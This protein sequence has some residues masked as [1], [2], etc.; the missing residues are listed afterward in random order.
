MKNTSL[1]FLPSFALLALLFS[2]QPN[3]EQKLKNTVKDYQKKQVDQP[4]KYKPG[5]FGE[6][7]SIFLEFSDVNEYKMLTDTSK[8]AAQIDGLSLRYENEMADNMDSLEKE[9]ERKK[10][11]LR[12]R[13]KS[14]EK[15][16]ENY[17][18]RLTKYVVPHTYKIA[19]DK[20]KKRFLV[21]TAYNVVGTKPAEKAE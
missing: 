9:L 16:K 21:D 12:E 17:E 7:D 11:N 14:I 1:A 20:H 10:E 5:Q 8:L 2:C 19:D 18:P 3:H 13:R 15:F 6:I 4:E